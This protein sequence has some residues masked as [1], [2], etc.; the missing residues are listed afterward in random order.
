MY[1]IYLKDPDDTEDFLAYFIDKNW[2]TFPNEIVF[3]PKS[4][5]KNRN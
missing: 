4:Q 5:E 2:V 1:D 3:F